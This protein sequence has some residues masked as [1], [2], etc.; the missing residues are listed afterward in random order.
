IVGIAGVD[1]VLALL[2]VRRPLQTLTEAMR[3]VEAGNWVA[4]V[5]LHGTDEVGA[6]LAEFNAMVRELGA[7]KRQLIDAAESREALEAGLQRLDKLATVGQLS[8][9]LVHEIGSPLQ[10][11]NGRAR[12]IAARADLP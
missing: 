1:W 2:L 6:A 4:S 12:A 3:S 7:A 5:P 10:I 8:A 9:G 11:L